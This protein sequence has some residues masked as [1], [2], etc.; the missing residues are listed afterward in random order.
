MAKNLSHPLKEHL[1]RRVICIDSA[2][3]GNE[4]GV[5][6]RRNWRLLVGQESELERKEMKREGR[7]IKER[8]HL[9]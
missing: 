1:M 9:L 7:K 8:T 2:M 3:L 6:G 5:G 4:R